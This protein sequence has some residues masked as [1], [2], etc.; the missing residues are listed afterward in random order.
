MEEIIKWYK[1]PDKKP[2]K[3]NEYLVHIQGE[4]VNEQEDNAWVS[5]DL[6]DKNGWAETPKIAVIEWAEMPKG[7]ISFL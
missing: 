2:K 4:H 3:N 6:F 5:I 1:Y 7:S